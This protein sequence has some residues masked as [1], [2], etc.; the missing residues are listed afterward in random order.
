MTIKRQQKQVVTNMKSWQKVENDSI[1]STSKVIS[2]S[3]NPVVRLVMEIIQHDSQ[4]HYRV[5]QWIADSLESKTVT[6]TPEEL[7]EIWDMIEHHIAIEKKMVENARKLLG[8]MED[9]AMP[10]Q[11]YLL[12][13][14]L[15]DEKKHANLLKYL[16][17]VKK[18][19]AGHPY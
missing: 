9:K 1:A 18:G 11:K 3:D 6:L 5:E 17:G 16:E 8:D 15:E 14:L 10:L 13:Y 7:I 4:T 2:K 19:S 12:Q